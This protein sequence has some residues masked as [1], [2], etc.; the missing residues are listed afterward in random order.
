MVAFLRPT[1]ALHGL[2]RADVTWLGH[3]QLRLPPLGDPS[4]R[5]V[6]TTSNHAEKLRSA[7]PTFHDIP[8]DLLARVLS[9]VHPSLK[10]FLVSKRW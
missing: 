3:G 1:C 4:V 8:D 2:L 7:A 5:A 10:F 9:F 6:K